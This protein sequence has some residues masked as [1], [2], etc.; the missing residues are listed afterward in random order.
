M[1]VEIGAG[2]SPSFSIVGSSTQI[3]VS[4]EAF[5][6]STVKEQFNTISVA[7]AVPTF[8]NMALRDLTDVIGAPTS[9]TVLI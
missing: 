6:T 1:S 7:T 2:S 3:S 9:H 4:Q 8:G 5:A